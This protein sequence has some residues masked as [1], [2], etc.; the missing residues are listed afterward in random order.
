TDPIPA[1]VSVRSVDSTQGS[2]TPG[3]PVVCR[4]GDLAD[5][6]TA[7]IT[8]H[9]VAD[10]AGTPVNTA[11]VSSPT[12]DP[13][14]SNNQD[15]TRLT[16]TARADLSVSKTPSTQTLLLGASFTYTL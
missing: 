9:A 8:I 14:T 6:A 5:G 3:D 13:N 10:R 2:C 1:G 4:L 15:S 16:T 7:T 12:P 11:I